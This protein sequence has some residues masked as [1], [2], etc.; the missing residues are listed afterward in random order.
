MNPVAF[1]I[2]PFGRVVLSRSMSQKE[3]EA[4]LEGKAVTEDE[5]F[6]AHEIPE[7][8]EVAN[9]VLTASGRVSI[10]VISKN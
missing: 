5:L 7:G 1:Q 10:N 3:Y 6:T 9:I 2:V 4:Y 8:Y